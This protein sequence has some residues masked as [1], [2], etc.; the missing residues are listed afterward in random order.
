MVTGDNRE[1]AVAVARSVGILHKQAD[2]SPDPSE[3]ILTGTE[4]EKLQDSELS[5]L[6]PRLRVVARVLPRDKSRL[7]RIAREAGMV[8]GMTGDGVNDAAA[9]RR[10]DVGFSMGGGTEI[11]KDASDIVILDNN[12]ASIAKAVLYGRTIFESIRKFLIFQLTMNFCAVG[13]S[14][15]AP[16]IGIDTPVTVLQMLWINLIMDTLA[17]LA[18]AG[19]APTEETMQRPPYHRNTPVLSRKML[20]RILASAGYCILLC[21]C[22]L[23]VPQVKAMFR[24]NQGDAVFM[25]AFFAL[26]IFSGIFLAFHARAEHR[27]FLVRW[28]QNP[29]F[30]GIMTCIFAVQLLLIYFG[31]SLFR[32]VPLTAKELRTVLLFALTVLPAG[33]LYKDG[34]ERIF[35]PKPAGKRKPKPPQEP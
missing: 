25:S 13:V 16:F 12:I 9:L 26:F 29:A 11:A 17:G 24:P 6:L 20:R 33:C 31:G 15:L 27:N 30:L 7:V 5:Q 3:V 22:F 35:S 19:E 32:T 21:L 18:F 14:I 23:K 34:R 1:T 10:A 28:R 4:L 8:V 2:G